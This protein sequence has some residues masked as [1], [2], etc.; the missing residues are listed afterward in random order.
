MDYLSVHYQKLYSIYVGR[1]TELF[2]SAEPDA[3]TLLITDEEK[4]SQENNELLIQ[5]WKKFKAWSL[6]RQNDIDLAWSNLF[7]LFQSKKIT[8]Y[9][10]L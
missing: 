5:L 2:P 6:A 9:E 8:Y 3:N 1:L 4:S 10:W 7:G